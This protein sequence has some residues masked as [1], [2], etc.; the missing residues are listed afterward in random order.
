M[1]ILWPALTGQ[2]ELQKTGPIKM[3]AD[4]FKKHGGLFRIKVWS[5]GFCFVNGPAA[6]AVMFEANDKALTQRE[7]YSFTVPVF[8]DG[9]VYDA[10]PKVMIQQLKFVRTGLAGAAMKTHA[11]KILQETTQFFGKWGDSGEVNLFHELCEL[12]I[13]TASR[14][15]LGREV[16]EKIYSR[17]A[18]L[19]Q[20]LE[21]GM[22]HLSV[23][24]PRL[25]TQAHAKRDAA[26]EEIA[27]LFSGIIAKRRAQ[28]EDDVKEDDFLQTLIDA[29]YRDGS[30]PTN[31]DITGL[32]LA[33][34]FAGQHTSS[35]TST[36][37]GLL[38][39]SKKKDLIPRILEEQKT[40]LD[41]YGGKLTFDAL[42]EMELL[43]NCM[44][45]A[46]RL[47]PPLVL[48]MRK[49]QQPQKFGE[50]VV[51]R[52]DVLVACP[53]VSHR[54]ESIY[55]NPE[56]FDPDRFARGEGSKK[57]EYIAFGAGRHACLGE[58]FAFL[59]VKTIWSILFRM[60]DFEM[61]NPTVPPVDFTSS[62]VAGP[63]PD[64]CR[65]R[66]KKRDNPIYL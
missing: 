26:R 2:F 19:Y 7:C 10:E 11:G 66:Y 60:Y 17:F 1:S 15:L 62:I 13:M 63:H 23:F 28:D 37:T 57:H 61:V 40:V 34:L 20:S 42:N 39:M 59:Q 6:N 18:D 31:E 14:C 12:T 8:G 58:K 64:L 5:Q 27:K 38:V 54:D 4:G 22:T 16:R 50:Y 55:S 51:P 47:F 46:L 24:F 25:P 30:S 43:H 36:W 44:K 9:I 3:V 65:V 48:L 56:E 49:V 21:R 33:A 41:K 45:E 35:I 52:G 29:R 32:L 53:P